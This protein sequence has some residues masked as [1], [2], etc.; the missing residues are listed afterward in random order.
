MVATMAR[1]PAMTSPRVGL[2][3]SGGGFRATAFGLGCQRAL[4]D[5]GVLRQVT[6]VSGISGGSLLAALWAYGPPNFEEFDNRVV[7]LLRQGLQLRLATGTVSPRRLAR[8]GTDLLAAAGPRG[9][10][11]ASRNRTDV[12]A[13][14]LAARAFGEKRMPDVTHPALATVLSATDLITSRAVRFGSDV[15]SGAGHGRIVEPIRVAEA[16][17][18]SA[19][20]PLLLPAVQ[21]TYTFERNGEQSRQ[22]VA[23][24]DGGVYD[25][26]GLSVLEPGRDPRF[27]DHVYPLDYVVAC[28]AGRQEPGTSA[29]R[30]LPFRL[31]RSFDITYRK[32]QDGTR[33]R[34]HMAGADGQIQGFI[35]AY[36]GQRDS[37]LPIPSPGLVPLDRVN[38]YGTNFKA[39]KGDDL[40]AITMRGEQ[41]TRL[42]LQHYCPA[43]LS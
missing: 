6:V 13:D 2:A 22:R 5:T 39:M 23:L 4:H 43:L 8:R 16:V 31:K 26:L 15:S 12:L 10:G 17:A 21:R 1:R 18:A 35:L 9:R 20:F 38:T 3:L 11:R 27:S 24:T 7:E 28:D 32:T 42:L 33:T 40:R 34:L 41:L 36:L 30:V 14:L 19:A 29:A 37:R 25:N